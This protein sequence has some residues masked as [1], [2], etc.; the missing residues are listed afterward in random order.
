MV[1]LSMKKVNLIFIGFF[2][3][4]FLVAS[5]WYPER[6]INISEKKESVSVQDDTDTIE[7]IPTCAGAVPANLEWYRTW[8]Y[9]RKEYGK[10]IALDSEE[11]VYIGGYSY[12]GSGNDCNMHVIKYNSSGGKEL[13]LTWDGG[14]NDLCFDVVIDNEDNIILTGRTDSYGVGK[15]DICVV[16]YDAQGNYLWNSTWGTAE[17]DTGTSVVCDSSGNIYVAGDV[18][19][20]PSEFATDNITVVKFNST[21]HF[22]WERRWGGPENDWAS[23]ICLD[24]NEDVIV[25]GSTVSL[26]DP[27]SDIV[28]IKYNKDGQ[29]EWVK[30]WGSTASDGAD[31]LILDSQDNIFVAGTTWGFDDPNGDIIL[32]KFNKTGD[33]KDHTLWGYSGYDGA[34]AIAMD[35]LENIYMG[36]AS[37]TNYFT[38]IKFNKTGAQ[39][40][41]KSWGSTGVA[42]RS[43]VVDS[44][45]NIYVAGFTDSMAAEYT[46]ML[47][48]KY[49]HSRPDISIVKPTLNKLIGKSAPEYELSIVEPYRDS[50]WYTINGSST[51]H[52]IFSDT[53]PIDQ[54]EW[55]TL[56]NGSLVLRFYA[57]NS[58]GVENFEDVIIYRDI[59]SPLLTIENPLENQE[60]TKDPPDVI[61]SFSEE[62]DNCWFT[63]DNGKH[64]ETCPIIFLNKAYGFISSEWW[65]NASYGNVTLQCWANDTVGN[66]GYEAINITKLAEVIAPLVSG[67]DDDRGGTDTE[68]I[69]GYHVILVIAIIISISTL[70]IKKQKLT[71][72]DKNCFFYLNKTR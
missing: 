36:G 13:E 56:H 44:Q 38:I 5:L 28:L 18:D 10:G 49:N 72:K 60:F 15:G 58:A 45:K 35:S 24:S 20:D 41:N 48:M 47:L 17:P 26:S 32:V 52:E 68:T 70:I 50:T 25:A 3:A 9:T 62:V 43:L 51:I 64:N 40:W 2:V 14:N 16:K 54:D 71:K 33:Y 53:G 12:W 65:K 31:D 34:R 37:E 23:A 19:E 27:D 59:I 8:S 66:I 1:K 69:P 11:N 29:R 61:V 21:G 46:D 39:L 6:V 67:G 22:K 4:T 7:T 57:N 63:I 42:C 55:N 30:N